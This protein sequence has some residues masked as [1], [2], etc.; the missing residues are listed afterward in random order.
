MNLYSS[1]F[2]S[3]CLKQC[4]ECVV[5]PKGATPD[6][7]VMAGRAVGRQLDLA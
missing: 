3:E 2:C 1:V 5:S 4:I 7:V 6:G